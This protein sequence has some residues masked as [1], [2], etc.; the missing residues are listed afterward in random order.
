[1]DM[2]GPHGWFPSAYGCYMYVVGI[3]VGWY[4]R[5]FVYESKR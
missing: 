3:V 1:M 2:T 4:A 5:R